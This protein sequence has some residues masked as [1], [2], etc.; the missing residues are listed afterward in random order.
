MAFEEAEDS[1]GTDEVLEEEEAEDSAGADES[2]VEELEGIPVH[3]A[4]IVMSWSGILSGFG[5]HPT[6][7]CPSLVGVE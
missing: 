7:V 4:T 3:C 6:N 5:S 1:A 2:E